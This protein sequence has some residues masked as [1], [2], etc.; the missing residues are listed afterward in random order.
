[1]GWT[2]ASE[3]IAGALIGWAVD[4]FS[5]RT[6]PWGVVVGTIAGVVV[7]MT[8]FLRSAFAANR[9]AMEA[10]RRRTGKEPAGGSREEG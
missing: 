5:G 6:A 1:M 10:A 9:E 8:T 4:H 3:I 2:L 7:G